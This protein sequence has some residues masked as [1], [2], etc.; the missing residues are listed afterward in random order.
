M[1]P[2]PPTP[3]LADAIVPVN[4]GTYVVASLGYNHWLNLAYSDT[5]DGA[6]VL[7]YGP[8]PTPTTNMIV[9]N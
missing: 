6:L 8:Q 5:F 3:L 1:V 7:A 9:C 4:N 2:P